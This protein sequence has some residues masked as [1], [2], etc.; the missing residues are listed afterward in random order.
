MGDEKNS[1][2]DKATKTKK[3]NKKYDK[4]SAKKGTTVDLDAV[5]F[6]NKDVQVWSERSNRERKVSSG[7]NLSFGGANLKGSRMRL[8]RKK[9]NRSSR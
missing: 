8:H 6:K 4:G 7:G 5:N 1:S 2:K 9:N 3:G